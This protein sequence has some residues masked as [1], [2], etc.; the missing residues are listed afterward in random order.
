[1][2]FMG[3]VLIFKLGRDWDSEAI[4]SANFLK[5]LKIFKIKVCSY[6]SLSSKL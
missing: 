1:M 4:H 6:Q 2:L 3:S 5:I